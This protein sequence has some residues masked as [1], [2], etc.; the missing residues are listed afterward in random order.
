MIWSQVCRV[1]LVMFDVC[2]SGVARNSLFVAQGQLTRSETQRLMV[3]KHTSLH[4][5]PSFPRDL[6]DLSSSPMSFTPSFLFFLPSSSP[7]HPTHTSSKILTSQALPDRKNNYAALFTP[8]STP[9][10]ALL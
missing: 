2:V 1:W 5:Y 8:L 10:L 7:L 9:D 3:S 4:K 6:A